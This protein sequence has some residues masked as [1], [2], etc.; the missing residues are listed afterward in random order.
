MSFPE[1]QTTQTAKRMRG[2]DLRQRKHRSDATSS[3]V[4]E[5]IRAMRSQGCRIKAISAATGLHAATIR[6]Y[7]V[8]IEPPEQ[9]LSWFEYTAG[10]GRTPVASNISLADLGT[11]IVSLSHGLSAIID[12]AD[13]DKVSGFR[14]YVTGRDKGRKRGYAARAGANGKH[15]FMH[16]IIC[17]VRDG[18]IVDHKDRD[19]LNNRADNLREA[20]HAGNAVN[21]TPSKKRAGYVGVSYYPKTDRWT[22]SVGHKMKRIH[23]GYFS[24][25][26]EAALA[27][28][29]A[30]LALHGEFAFV[31]FPEARS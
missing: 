8:G 18:F 1:I 2:K 12:A 3:A 31:N 15:I 14:W 16:H 22:A 27:R 13:I 23:V 19:T 28:D 4:I 7:V 20:T 24:T 30:A 21:K 29:A 5:K 26:R 9:G 6:K 25:A 11:A 10:P 17:P